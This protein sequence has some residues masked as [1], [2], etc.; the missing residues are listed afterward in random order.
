MNAID[1][2]RIVEKIIETSDE[3]LLEEIKILP[4]IADSENWESVPDSVK[5]TITKSLQD[6]K[7]GRTTPH[8]T[9]LGEVKSKY[10]K[11]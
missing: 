8:S 1:K 10:L 5:Q 4:G 9:F 7:E 3:A 6:I 2:Y 11:S